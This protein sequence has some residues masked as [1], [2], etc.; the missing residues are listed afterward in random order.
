MNF[1]NV[2]ARCGV[3]VGW[4]SYTEHHGYWKHQNSHSTGLVSCGLDPVPV[5]RQT[6]MQMREVRTAQRDP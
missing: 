4:R 3:N 1:R 5:N 2:C 6:F